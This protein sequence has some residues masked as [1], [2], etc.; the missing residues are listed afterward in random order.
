MI[1]QEQEPN[2]CFSCGEEFV[3]H[4][5]YDSAEVSFCPFCGSE[6]DAEEDFDDEDDIF[7]EAFDE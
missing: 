2:V 4:T 3:V 7:G 6:I 1:E 5:S